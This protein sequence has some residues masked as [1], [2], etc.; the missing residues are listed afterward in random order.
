[1]YHCRFLATGLSYS[2]LAYTFRMGASTVASIVAETCEALW[3]VLQPVHMPTPD[4]NSCR[5]VEE[6]FRTKWNFPNCFGCIDGKHVRV[7]CPEQ[8][9]SQFY[10]YKQYF[11]I[12][13][14][15]VADANCKFI[16]IDVGGTAKQSDGGIFRNSDLY[17]C[18]E[19][20]AFNVPTAAN[21][22]GTN[23][24]TP[25]VILGD[26]AYPLLTYLMRPFPRASLDDQRKFSTTG[27][28]GRGV[29]W[30]AH[31]E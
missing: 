9:G 18:L 4:E 8:S 14:Q 6:G 23:I 2:G 1:M 3:D 21:L 5:K 25:Y 10:N 24:K 29:A 27:C 12:V 15:G 22:P 30:N 19:T 31:L 7:I 26:E 28:Q 20:N 17:I 11:S 13:L 16:T